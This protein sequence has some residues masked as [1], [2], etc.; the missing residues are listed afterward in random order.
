M[1]LSP[2]VWRTAIKSSKAKEQYQFSQ[3]P[4]LLRSQP[5]LSLLPGLLL[6]EGLCFT[7]F[8]VGLAQ[9]TLVTQE[10]LSLLKGFD[11]FRPRN[12]HVYPSLVIS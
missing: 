9:F 5:F 3:I 12:S 8:S 6:L 10:T 7:N 11:W 1:R 2:G 4:S